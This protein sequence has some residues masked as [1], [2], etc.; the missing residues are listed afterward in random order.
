MTEEDIN[1]GASP[2]DESKADFIDLLAVSNYQGK[3][4]DGTWEPFIWEDDEEPTPESTG[5]SEVEKLE[6]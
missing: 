5:Y 2:L 6:N 3:R 1:M 4:D